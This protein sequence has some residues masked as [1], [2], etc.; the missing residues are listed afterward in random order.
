M[1]KQTVKPKKPK[2]KL[3][4]WQVQACEKRDTTKVIPY[5]ARMG[6]KANG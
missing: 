1:S 5:H 4:P 6:L 3:H 2:K